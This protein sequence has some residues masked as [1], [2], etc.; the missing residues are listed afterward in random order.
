[1]A[2]DKLAPEDPRATHQTA[3]IRG[4]KYHYLLA[5]PTA[6]ATGTILLAHGFPDLSLGW[7]YQVPLLAGLG[8]RVVVPDM[9]GYGRTDSPSDLAAFSHKSMAADLAAL[10]EHVAPGERVFLGGHDWG[11]SLAWRAA[12]W[13]PGL[14][15]GVFVV[16]TPF[17]P[18]E[19][20]YVDVETLGKIVPSFRY[21][22]QLAGPDVEREIAG[23]ARLRQ[24]LN[25][26]YGGR[27]PAGEL[28]FDVSRGVLF[29]NLPS[30]GPSPLLDEAE[31]DYYVAEF[32]RSGMRGPTNW[33]RMRRINFDE[34][35]ELVGEGG[36][37]PVIKVPSLF[38][39]ARDDAALPPSLADGMEQWFDSL[40]KEV[41]PGGHWAL[42]QSADEANGHIADF[43]TGLIKA[44]DAPKA[45][46]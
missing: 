46:I 42:W 5:E 19:K 33:Y 39:A 30:M 1:M 8:L 23:E 31:V 38:I 4:R 27:G 11:G 9:L 28:A 10:A 29:D 20:A 40:R 13:H 6:P 44:G 14:F 18:P 25:G 35:R 3:T 26:V 22:A 37:D 2:P 24:F 34:E 36:A 45:S 21:Q 16:C 12:L 15:R 7:R 41:V 43:L 17:R 32:A